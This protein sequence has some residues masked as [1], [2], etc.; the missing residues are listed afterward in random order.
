MSRA[1]SR[2]LVVQKW[3]TPSGAWGSVN[4]PRERRENDIVFNEKWVYERPR[5]E[6]GVRRRIIYWRRY[7]F[8]ASLLERE[9]GELVRE[10]LGVALAGELRD[11]RYRSQSGA[12]SD[13]GTKHPSE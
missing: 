2:N 5:G 13:P 6:P 12:A 4:E 7:D 8:V 1:A 9:D 3:G 10:D 11:R